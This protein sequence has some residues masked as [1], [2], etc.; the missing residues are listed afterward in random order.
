MAGR[1]SPG[2]HATGGRIPLQSAPRLSREFKLGSE[3]ARSTAAVRCYQLARW[4]KCLK[5]AGGARQV[6]TNAGDGPRQPIEGTNATLLADE[7]NSEREVGGLR[8]FD[9]SMDRGRVLESRPTKIV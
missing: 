2:Q 5:H 1:S 9:H 4:R 8:C 6:F 3:S 7:S